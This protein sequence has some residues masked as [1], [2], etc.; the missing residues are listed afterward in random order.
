MPTCPQC[1]A[2]NPDTAKFCSQCGSRLQSQRL[3]RERRNVSILFIDLSGFSTL[4]RNWLPEELRDLAD[5][6]L[7]VVAGIVEDYDGHVD[8]FQGD[9]LIAL[10]GAPHSH[11]DDPQRAVLAAVSGLRAIETIGRSKGLE[12][13]GRAGVNTGVVIA[14]AI[15]SGRVREYTVMGS[16]VNLAARLE[17]AA[18]PG[19]VWVG[20]E[21]YEATRHRMVYETIREVSLPGF[22]TVTEVYRLLAVAEPDTADPYSHLR[23][24]GR[25]VELA[26]LQEALAQVRQ[27]RQPQTV[28]V[29][30]EVGMGKTRLVK[31]FTEQLERQRAATVLWCGEELYNTE[32]MWR[33]LASA[34]FGVRGDDPHSWQQLVLGGVRR[35]LPNEP[36]WQ[37]YV[38]G[39]LGLTQMQP[40]RRI[41]RRRVDRTFIAWRDLLCAMTQEEA[42]PGCLVL[43]VEHSSQHTPF[44]TLPDLLAQS[45]VPALIIRTSRKRD[46]ATDAKKLVLRPLSHQESTELVS[47]LANPLLKVATESLIFQ[48]GGIPANL[49]ELGRALSITPQGS[50][51]GSLAS[52]L[53]ARLD[54]LTA[55]ARQLL[56]FAALCGERSWENLMMELYGAPDHDA[57]RQLTEEN[58]LMKEPVSSIPDQAE[59]RFQS[60]L[61]RRAVLRMIPFSERPQLH[62]RIAAWLER[63]APLTLSEQIARHFLEGGTPE[64]AY[65]FYLAAADLEV[66]HAKY[67]A[68]YKHYETL[69]ALE[70]P[71]NLLAQGALAYAQAAI[72]ACDASKALEQLGAADQ[73]IEQLPGEAREALRSVHQKLCEDLKKQQGVQ[74]PQS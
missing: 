61:L 20:P 58:L 36:R 6:I 56:A 5:E 52:L 11:H 14:G 21:T 40:W 10:F 7:T 1:A 32:L 57:L 47:Q 28:W 9:G 49:L 33:N 73:W 25:Q 39:S 26:F 35:L 38:L 62:L 18:P 17:A 30:G 51:S 68:A 13:K 37:R 44:S 23:F 24:V 29:V 22:P 59:Y 43:V 64:A 70:L 48:V 67:S 3:E 31:T 45:Q 74:Q 66:S 12:L 42:F 71:A 8:A 46:L 63:F 4:T 16:A 72:A 27:T 19:E 65:P 69:L 2:L 53:Q 55:P 15:G 50:F 41:E 34:A 60:E 54:M